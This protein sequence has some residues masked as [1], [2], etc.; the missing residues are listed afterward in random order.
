MNL[1]GLFVLLVGLLNAKAVVQENEYY[2]GNYKK[3]CLFKM[4]TVQ[5]LY[6]LYCALNY[7]EIRVGA[8]LKR[9]IG[10]LY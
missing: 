7:D 9:K 6:D 8:E 4:E 1:Y 5:I 10:N 2:P 3:N